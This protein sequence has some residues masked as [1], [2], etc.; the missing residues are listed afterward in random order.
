MAPI[1]QCEM[2]TLGLRTRFFIQ[3]II[4][5]KIKMK[6][7]IVHEA[8]SS[9]ILVIRCNRIVSIDAIKHFHSVWTSVAPV[10]LL[11]KVYFCPSFFGPNGMR[12][13]L[14]GRDSGDFKRRLN[15][16]AICWYYSGDMKTLN[17]M[18]CRKMLIVSLIYWF[19]LRTDGLGYYWVLRQQ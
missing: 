1:S 19:K 16:G 8:W 2:W 5:G 6:K 3:K 7:I 15:H 17:W 11:E 12:T 9:N 14:Y 13:D 18:N 4:C 10:F